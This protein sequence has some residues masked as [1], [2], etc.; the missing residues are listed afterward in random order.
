[1]SEEFSPKLAHL[2]AE[3]VH[4]AAP[5]GPAAALPA[6]VKLRHRGLL[7]SFVLMVLLPATAAS[8]YLLAVARDQYASTIGFT[9][10]S[11]D[12]ALASDF[13]G[14]LGAAFG[15]SGSGADSEILYEF[16]RSQEMV[17]RIDDRLDLR[18]LYARFFRED[19]LMSYEPGGTI[20]DLT[21][22]W[23]R[24]LRVSYDAGSGLMEV[25][26]LAFEPHDAQA[27]AAAVLDESSSMINGL[28]A[29]ARDDATRYARADVDRA[30]RLV[31]DAREA[32]TTFRLRY[33]ID[34]P[35]AD[36][37]GQAGLLN[38]L[39]VQLAEALISYDLLTASVQSDDPRIAK[40]ENRI[41]VIRA[42]MTAERDKF[43]AEGQGPGGA[44]YADAIA[45]FE[46][47]MADREFAEL[48]YAA[49][50]A[51]LDAAVAESQRQSRYLVAYI[52]HSA[53][54]KSEF[55]QRS[56]I[57]AVIAAFS[58]LAWAILSLVYYSLRDRR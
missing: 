29:L 45:G 14:G 21:D 43:G 17:R 4:K 35:E 42:R 28:A 48:T 24:M 10:R 11:S 52:H 22:Y 39:Q 25:R 16:I 50:R 37:K 23:D 36:I 58:F 6:T 49:S 19:P 27:I 7:L 13:L 38:T 41:G 20:E 1:M 2:N 51:A 30:E 34:D 47:L 40:A 18:T 56:L 44:T 9:V 31:S 8:Y 53:V 32:L 55:P 15:S 3:R 33:R 12:S 5:G 46:R 57:I 54:E 26:V